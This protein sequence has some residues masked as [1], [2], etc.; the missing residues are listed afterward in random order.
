M[1]KEQSLQMFREMGKADAI[2][3]RGRAKDMDGTG[4][5]AEEEKIPAFDPQ[6]DY[7][8]WP[9]GSPVADEEQ[10]WVLIQPYNAAWYAGRPSGLRALW[11]LCHTNDPKK[12]KPWVEPYGTSGM[13]MMD[14]CY[15][16]EDGKVWKCL[17][18]NVVYDAKTMPS[19]WE[20]VEVT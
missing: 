2:D 4:I 15:R 16:D 17:T 7:S 10:V 12:A 9:V 14:E 6:H 8:A 20:E 19:W 18:N 13:Y 3:L 11:G 5:I 1:T